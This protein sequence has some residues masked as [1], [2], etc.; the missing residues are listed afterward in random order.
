MES[1]SS[2][3]GS[4]NSSGSILAIACG[5][6]VTTWDINNNSSATAS[7]QS[8]SSKSH[9][10]MIVV[11][12]SIDGGRVAGTGVGVEQFCPHGDC[13]VVDLAWNHNG[14]GKS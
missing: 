2:T 13:S 5:P 7:L 6:L 3:A 8:P 9:D 10:S 1:S 11:G 14:Q 4:S 12:R